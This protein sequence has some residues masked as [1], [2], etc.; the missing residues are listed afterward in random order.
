MHG[1][2]VFLLGLGYI[3]YTAQYIKEPYQHTFIKG[4]KGLSS[5]GSLY[6][7]YIHKDDKNLLDKIDRGLNF[8]DTEN[9]ITPEDR[10]NTITYGLN[11]LH[12]PPTL[13]H[14][15]PRIRVKRMVDG[16]VRLFNEYYD[17]SMEVVMLNESFEDIY[18]ALKDGVT[19]FEYDLTDEQ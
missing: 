8:G 9:D 3:P 6:N 12:H 11:E 10:K 14:P 19:L 18:K 1:F 5:M 4:Y 7:V 13:R 16:K 17:S 15:R 2:E